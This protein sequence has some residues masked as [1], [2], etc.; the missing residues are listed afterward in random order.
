MRDLLNGCCVG[1]SGLVDA[2]KVPRCT[3]VKYSAPQEAT[4]NYRE[5][6]STHACV[7]RVPGEFSVSPVASAPSSCSSQP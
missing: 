4:V 6:Y 5:Q 2:I 7:Y 3:L 1:K